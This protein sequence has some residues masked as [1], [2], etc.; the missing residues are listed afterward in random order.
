MRHSST[1]PAQCVPFLDLRPS[2][3]GL[4]VE[5]L[6][7]VSA[8]VDS[9][10]YTNGPDVRLF[11]EE[12]AAYCGTDDAVGVASGLDALRLSLLACGVEAGDEVI[13]PALTFVATVEA[14]T[15]AGARPVLIDVSPDDYAIDPSQVEAAI[16]PRTRAIL[17]VHLYGQLADMRRLTVLAAD[18]DIALV[19]DAC[20]AHGAE[21]AGRRAGASGVAGCFSFY[22]GKNLGAMGD[23]GAVTTSDAALAGRVRAL[24]EHGQTAKYVHE[25]E[26]YTARLDTIQ[27]L[28]LRHKLPFLEKW[29]EERRRAAGVYLERL[30]NVGD[31][32]LP[33]IALESRPAWHL[34]VVTT[35]N[36]NGL[37][38]F[39]ARR[40]IGAARHY[41]DPVHRTPAYN[42]LGHAEGAFPVAE[43][44]AHTVLSLPLYPGI[45]EQQLDCVI[46]EIRDYF[47]RA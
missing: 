23:A 2:H 22:P 39:L 34:F 4:K 15:Q 36:P 25:Y 28:V 47:D 8:L 9:N 43:R 37:A 5:L 3:A 6:E 30:E 12:F 44:L 42:D 11:E 26:G 21:R 27:A 41:P 46:D 10:S 31:L 35:A 40:G 16:S 20:Q 18:A 1:Q 45:S 14:I 7:A 33:A 24:R 17:P 29:N 38:D 13:V 19:E 32:G